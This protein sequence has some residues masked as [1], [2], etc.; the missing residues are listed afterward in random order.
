MNS[1]EG[2][3]GGAGG[4]SG[5]AAEEVAGLVVANLLST[6]LPPNPPGSTVPLRAFTSVS[7]ATWVLRSTK[8]VHSSVPT[9][10]LLGL[11]ILISPMS[12]CT[13]PLFL[14]SSTN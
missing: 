3:A 7:A 2:A 13:S 6:A 8:T 11:Q 5:R 12:A 9:L 14:K 10:T 1:A 4:L